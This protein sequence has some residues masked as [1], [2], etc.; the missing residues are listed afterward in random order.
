MYGFVVC[1]KLNTDDI[2]EVCLLPS[3]Q[4][5]FIFYHGLLCSFRKCS[6]PTVLKVVLGKIAYDSEVSFFYLLMMRSEG[7][8]S[9]L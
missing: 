3:I 2:V 4:S 8:E 7:G 5:Y 1:A 6:F 9:Y